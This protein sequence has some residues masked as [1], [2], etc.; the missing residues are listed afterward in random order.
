[1]RVWALGLLRNPWISKKA[2][3]V[4]GFTVMEL[5]LS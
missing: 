4:V 3:L 2:L 5:G 1:L